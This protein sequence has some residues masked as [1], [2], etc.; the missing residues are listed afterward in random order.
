MVKLKTIWL[1]NW[2]LVLNSIAWNYLTVVNRTFV[3]E[4]IGWNYLTTGKQMSSGSINKFCF[5]D[6][7]LKE[8]HSKYKQ[9]LSL[10]NHQGYICHYTK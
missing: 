4:S 6:I 10:N 1:V 7:H 9:Y 3:L 2:I 8:A 5:Q